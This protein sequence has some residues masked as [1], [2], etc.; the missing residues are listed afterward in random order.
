MR[1]PKV[2]PAKLIAPSHHD[3]HDSD[4]RFW[5]DVDLDRANR[6]VIKTQLSSDYGRYTA[7]EDLI[8]SDGLL[9]VSRL[10]PSSSSSS[11]SSSTS[12]SSSSSSVSLVRYDPHDPLTRDAYMCHDKSLDIMYAKGWAEVRGAEPLD[13]AA[14]LFDYTSNYNLVHKSQKGILEFRTV[15][16]VSIYHQVLYLHSSAPPPFQSRDFVWSC[17]SKRLSDDV[18]VFV[19]KSTVHKDAPV[20][21][22]IVRA[23]STRIFKVSRGQ[24]IDEDWELPPSSVTRIE[25]FTTIDLKGSMPTYIARTFVI[26]AS[27][28]FSAP[29]YFMHIKLYEDYDSA[30]ED[31][32]MLAQLLFN[33]M[34]SVT[35]KTKL[36][37]FLLNFFGR[38]AALRHLSAKYPYWFEILIF[39]IASSEEKPRGMLKHLMTRS[40]SNALLSNNVHTLATVT[41]ASATDMGASLVTLLHSIRKR[42]EFS[43]E[44]AV[45]EWIYKDS[46]HQVLKELTDLEPRFFRP[47]V[48]CIAQNVIALIPGAS[49]SDATNPAS[50]KPADGSAEVRL[51]AFG[52][53][54][55]E[56]QIGMDPG[57]FSLA[58]PRSA[59]SQRQLD[60]ERQL[61]QTEN[62]PP[63]ALTRNRISSIFSSGRAEPSRVQL[64]G[65]S[66][67]RAS[68]SASTATRRSTRRLMSPNVVVHA[69]RRDETSAR[70]K[71]IAE[72]L[73]ASPESEM[74]TE[75]EDN[76][77][78]SALTVLQLTIQGAAPAF[79]RKMG[80]VRSPTLPPLAVEEEGASAEQE[81]SSPT[82]RGSL[83]SMRGKMSTRTNRSVGR[84][85][86]SS[87]VFS[88]LRLRGVLDLT[89]RASKNGGNVSPGFDVVPSAAL[90]DPALSTTNV[91]N[92]DPNPNSSLTPPPRVDDPLGLRLQRGD[93][94]KFPT[95]E[96]CF[97][98]EEFST[99]NWIL[100]R[101]SIRTTA[102]EA[103]SYRLDEGCWD[104]STDIEL[105]AFDEISKHH[106][107]CDSILNLPG[108]IS[109]RRFVNVNLWKKLNGS[110]GVDA[111]GDEWAFINVPIES[112]KVPESKN[113]IRGKYHSIMHLTMIEKDLCVVTLLAKADVMLP[114]PSFVTNNHLLSE[115]TW[116]EKW[117][118]FY[119]ERR[120]LEQL[121]SRD[122]AFFAEALMKGMENIQAEARA[123]PTVATIR[124]TLYRSVVPELTVRAVTGESSNDTLQC[125]SPKFVSH[126]RSLRDKY[127]ALQ[128]LAIHV[129][130]HFEY[131]MH[132]IVLNIL[133]NDPPPKTPL[134][135]LSELEAYQLGRAFSFYLALRSSITS[136]IRE[137]IA[138]SPALTQLTERC[139]WMLQLFETCALRFETISSKQSYSLTLRRQSLAFCRG[140]ELLLPPVVGG[141]ESADVSEQQSAELDHDKGLIMRTMQPHLGR[142][143]SEATLVY[144][145]VS[146]YLVNVAFF[147]IP[148]PHPFSGVENNALFL[149][150]YLPALA[151][152]GCNFMTSLFSV[153][154]KLCFICAKKPTKEAAILRF[155]IHNITYAALVVPFLMITYPLANTV[156][157]PVPWN[158]ICLV[159]FVPSGSFVA[160]LYL[161]L[162]FP[163]ETLM[164]KKEFVSFIKIIACIL[165][166][167][168]IVPMST[169]LYTETEGLVQTAVITGLGL[170]RE[171]EL[172]MVEKLG[173]KK[174]SE[175]TLIV[176]SLIVDVFYET[177][178][179][180]LMSKAKLTLTLVLPPVFD[181]LGNLASFYWIYHYLREDKAAQTLSLVTLAVREL[182]EIF[183]SVGVTLVVSGAWY[184]NR[185][186]F[187][188]I[189]SI[190]EEQ[191]VRTFYMALVDLFAEVFV[192]WIFNKIVFKVY[193]V[194]MLDLV[195][196]F[197]RS[198]G[199]FEFFAVIC[200]CVTLNFAILLY[201]LG[202][203]YYFRF[204]WMEEEGADWCEVRQRK[205]QSCFFLAGNDA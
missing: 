72:I 30:G 142:P 81:S 161:R 152:A 125:S 24:Q 101:A 164:S 104:N 62:M 55:L 156:A 140:T 198:I 129:F 108:G 97:C 79:V 33:G 52:R 183:A 19:L 143:G 37:G 191:L 159:L 105:R 116:I 35:D 11:S 63:Q 1:M 38:T 98:S 64:S 94:H 172:L 134:E 203:D 71:M 68:G 12:S 205:Q 60:L 187:Y 36:A 126:Y 48:T 121:D 112:D 84:Q 77:I 49:S 130:P 170:L 190:T 31:A 59:E 65:R 177:Q 45:D 181:L 193:R 118:E 83:A 67:A 136:A 149:Y 95:L 119:Y 163:N 175:L 132:G 117:Q 32:A 7:A 110:A 78:F 196:A 106:Y 201:H 148:L 144:S 204:R 151:Y 21:P 93:Q 107:K 150:V 137:W 46:K 3:G 141:A 73:L 86:R 146:A 169:G 135:L 43:A 41:K 91:L 34:R 87:Q 123:T 102:K 50:R 180:M 88:S 39:T 17:V 114:I 40:A 42:N 2:A 82:S 51:T 70:Q 139:P 27:I 167:I 195:A 61:S 66:Q 25:L 165:P 158:I 171:A 168:L 174:V 74:Y 199:T 23:E 92:S 13:V 26:P 115:P 22:H 120:A 96:Y 76:A 85:T 47:F 20:K 160:W 192:F 128:Q 153:A 69:S 4:D 133:V 122:G 182:I 124:K 58:P 53:W 54:Y 173:Y 147:S 194:R 10:S 16:R 202:S 127:T 189:D 162:T 5:K 138:D 100:V 131:L 75:D 80:E 103:M 15:E 186:S 155:K 6:E 56:Q 179:I 197:S 113:F 18:Y 44:A 90:Q 99:L 89:T 178:M 154:F 188:M 14:F 185:S 200:G 111:P 8:L 57:P 176:L 28:N 184:F 157:F 29:L 109:P 9:V 145:V 166:F